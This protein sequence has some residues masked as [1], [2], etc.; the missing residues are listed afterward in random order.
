[1]PS[2]G[3]HDQLSAYLRGYLHGANRI[4]DDSG[5]AAFADILPVHLLQGYGVGDT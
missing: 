1:M 4:S 2:D 5:L 3:P